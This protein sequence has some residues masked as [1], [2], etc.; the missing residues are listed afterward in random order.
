MLAQSPSNCSWAMAQAGNPLDCSSSFRGGRGRIGQLVDEARCGWRMP[1]EQ[2]DVAVVGKLTYGVQPGVSAR[3][4]EEVSYF[5]AIRIELITEL[6]Q[7]QGLPG[8]G[9][10]RTDHRVDHD[11]M[12]SEVVAYLLRIAFTVRSESSLA[13]PAA[14]PYVLGLSMA[15]YEQSASLMHSRSLRRCGALQGVPACAVLSKSRS[16]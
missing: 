1:Y 15:K 10:A 12:L 11:A 6:E 8:A 14:R 9:C 3:V 4:I 16:G 13:V 7:L 5:H 2:S